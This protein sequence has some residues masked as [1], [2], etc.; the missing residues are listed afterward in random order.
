MPSCSRNLKTAFLAKRLKCMKDT[1]LQE[2]HCQR[3]GRSAFERTNAMDTTGHGTSPTRTNPMA[4]SHN[5]M[6]FWHYIVTSARVDRFSADDNIDTD[7]AAHQL[8]PADTRANSN[9]HQHPRESNL[10][11]SIA[12]RGIRTKLSRW[13]QTSGLVS[14]GSGNTIKP[15]TRTSN[16]ECNWLVGGCGNEAGFSAIRMGNGSCSFLAF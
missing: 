10:S 7:S 9:H 2:T 11:H 12:R 13:T 1:T 5:Q 14:S 6:I 15:P 16:C 3:L 8:A 4:A